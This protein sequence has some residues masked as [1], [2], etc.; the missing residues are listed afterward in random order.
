MHS[1][2][3][4][5]GRNEGLDLIMEYKFMFLKKMRQKGSSRIHTSGLLKNDEFGNKQYP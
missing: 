4:K 5:S 3:I 2:G 1:N